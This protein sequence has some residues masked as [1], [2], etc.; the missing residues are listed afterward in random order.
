MRELYSSVGPPA[1]WGVG[2]CPSGGWRL[3][4]LRGVCGVLFTARGE[5]YNAAPGTEHQKHQDRKAAV[6]LC[7]SGQQVARGAA[8]YE[9]FGIVLS[10]NEEHSHQ[11]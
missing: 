8:L 11:I 9:T 4:V 3:N 5:K 2:V 10:Q 7:V 6:E 1:R